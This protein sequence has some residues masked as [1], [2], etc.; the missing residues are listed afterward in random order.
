[1]ILQGNNKYSR[2]SRVNGAERI[3]TLNSIM[4]VL[5]EIHCKLEKST[6]AYKEEPA[7]D[8]RCGK[9]YDY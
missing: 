3:E 7:G 5:R 1:M 8:I 2:E 6:Y 9:K 4:Y